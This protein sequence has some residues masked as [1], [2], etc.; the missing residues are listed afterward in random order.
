MSKNISPSVIIKS[1]VRLA[2]NLID[3]PFAPVLEDACRKEIIEKVEQGLDGYKKIDAKD[4]Y[5]LLAML[6]EENKVSR[7]FAAEE[8][9]HALFFNEVQNVYVMVC[10]EDHL[11]LQAFADGL[12]LSE[13]GNKILTVSNILGEKL[14]YAYNNDLGFLTH[15]PTNLGTALRASVMMFLP[16]LTLS[17]RMGELKT[18]LEKIGITI[19]G[20]YGEGSSADAFIYQI[21]NSLSLGI[22][23]ADI[24][25][26]IETVATRIANDEL[27]ARAAIFDFSPDKL[28]DK[29]MR[30]VGTLRYAHL[31]ST[32][33]FLDCYSYVRLGISM[34][35]VENISTTSLDTLLYKAMPAHIIWKH[36]DAANDSQKRDVLRARTVKKIFKE[37]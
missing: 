9:R 23:E 25:K 27:D 37:E 10:E 13:A 11:R 8:E 29:I 24:F 36:P 1:R 26:K 6:S 21:S 31:L 32:E 3:Y 2:R 14:R 28:T 20:I 34:N 4:N 5:L 30:S 7:E 22:S 12:A 15:C 35:L 18:Q 19:R 16:A 17:N 33:E